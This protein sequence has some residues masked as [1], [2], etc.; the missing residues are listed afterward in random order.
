MSAIT[1]SVDTAQY[2]SRDAFIAT[3][4][5]EDSQ[6]WRYFTRIGPEVTLVET[7]DGEWERHPEDASL[8]WRVL[9]PINTVIRQAS[10]VKCEWEAMR[11]G[12]KY[13]VAEPGATIVLKSARKNTQY[14]HEKRTRNWFKEPFIRSGRWVIGCVVKHSDDEFAIDIFT[15]EGQKTVMLCHPT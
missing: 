14:G 9:A 5:A 1:H 4:R 8:Y 13:G 3:M 11:D 7:F 6:Q 10:L 15:K 12:V 2:V